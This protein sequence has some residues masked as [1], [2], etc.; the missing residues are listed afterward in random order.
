MLI[1]LYVTTLVT[2]I[3]GAWKF[4]IECG[5]GLGLVL[6]L[7]WYWWR[8]NAWSEISATIAPFIGYG[9]SKLVFKLEFPDSFFLTVGFTTLVWVTV[10]YLTPAT[11]LETLK[12]F[13]NVVKP[14]GNWKRIYSRMNIQPE[15]GKLIKLF[16]SW[17]SSVSMTYS[18][19]FFFGKFIFKEYDKAGL[20]FLIT[21]VSFLVLKRS[22]KES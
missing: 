2:S 1:A 5:A 22:M 17:I 12:N 4:L 14:H 11:S 20:W 21:L 10:T 7:R 15:K 16:I 19:L 6:I 9:I 18:V 8:I 3:S 13:Y